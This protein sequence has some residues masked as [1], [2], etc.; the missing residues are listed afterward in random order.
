MTRSNRR[1]ARRGFLLI[2]MLCV[3]LLLTL[4]TGILALMMK[5]ALH[6]G[7]AQ[8]AGFDR[9]L[10]INALADAFRADVAEAED[11]PESWQ[12]YRAGA[13]TLVLTMP[14]GAHVIYTWED[15]L[16]WRREVKNGEMSERNTAVDESRQPGDDPVDVSF[17]RDVADGRLVR[18]RV[19]W[20]R[21]GSPLAGQSLTID[22]ALGGDR[23]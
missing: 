10:A 1:A 4:L 17:V 2:E 12:Q 5:E 21:R 13:T 8:A 15:R 23:R 7:R 16:L 9:A 3:I 14:D 19:H 6:A 11:A 22:A 18:L 20:T